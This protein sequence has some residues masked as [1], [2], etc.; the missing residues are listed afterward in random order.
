VI[1]EA[2]SA[3]IPRIV[4]MGSRF[5]AA[6]G[7][8]AGYDEA[9]VGQLLAGLIA[10]DSGCLFVSDFGMIGGALIPAY[11]DP[12]WIMAVEMFW[13]AERDGLSL[14]HRFEEW[15]AEHGA[16]EVRMTSLASLPRADAILRRK[17]FAPTEISYQKVI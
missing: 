16:H 2:V 14:L 10:S 7:I 5:H 11:C 3:D 17:G 1:R 9:A 6:S 15:A 13:W 4:E 12:S 8:R